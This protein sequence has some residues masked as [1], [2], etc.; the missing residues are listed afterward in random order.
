MK[1]WCGTEAVAAD[2]AVDAVVGEVGVRDRV[3]WAA[4]RQPGQAAIVSAPIA[5]TR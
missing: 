5:A 4:L 3:A 1:I 2:K